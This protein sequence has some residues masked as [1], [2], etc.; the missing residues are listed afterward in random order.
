MWFGVNRSRFGEEPFIS[1]RWDEVMH[2]VSDWNPAKQCRH[3]LDGIRFEGGFRRARQA[4]RYATLLVDE[5]SP[6]PP[7][8]TGYLRCHATRA[9]PVRYY[10]IRIGTHPATGA[11]FTRYITA[12]ESIYR[13]LRTDSRSV[14][15]R[16]DNF[17]AACAYMHLEPRDV[18]PS[19]MFPEFQVALGPNNPWLDFHANR[20]WEYRTAW[21]ARYSLTADLNAVAEASDP[22]G[23]SS[24]LMFFETY[25]AARTGG[26]R[27]VGHTPEA[28][29]PQL[30]SH[31]QAPATRRSTDGNPG[32]PLCR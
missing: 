17:D 31:R 20:L 24:E 26:D 15:A 5:R 19:V 32:V 23:L 27:S 13:A 2:L 28:R 14:G 18:P 25:L 7:S 9:A 30:R 22:D 6:Y 12:D 29:T 10:A 8:L 16:F 11:C 1:Q 21:G 4:W 3:F